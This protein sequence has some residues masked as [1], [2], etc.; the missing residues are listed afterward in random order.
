MFRGTIISPDGTSRSQ[1]F[2]TSISLEINRGKFERS[3]DRVRGNKSWMETS[4]RITVIYSLEDN[5]EMYNV[6][7]QTFS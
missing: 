4:R 1:F 2:I 7:L 5:T 3:Q 6:Y